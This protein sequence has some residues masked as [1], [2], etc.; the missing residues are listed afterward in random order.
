MSEEGLN[1]LVYSKNVIEL[2]TVANEFCSFVERSEEMETS[3]FLSRLQKLLPLLYLKASLLPVFSLEADDELEKYVTEIDYNLIQQK[4]LRH[5]GAGDDY[6]EIFLSGMQFSESA[7]TASIAENV[8]DIYQ[9]MKDLVMSFRTLDE[10]VMELALSE[11]QNNFS[12]L[13]GQ[14]LVNCLR[15]IHNLIYG[16][17]DDDVLSAKNQNIELK[18]LNRKPDWLNDRFSNQEE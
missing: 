13:W 17:P 7:L 2:I 1:S 15:A 5:T 9:D 12:Q 18:N 4:I 10:E 3:D 6:Q 11:C 16:E 14:K 8:A